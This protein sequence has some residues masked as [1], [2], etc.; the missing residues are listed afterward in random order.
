MKKCITIYLLF[1]TTFLFAQTP[2]DTTWTKTFGGSEYEW[3]RAVQQTS[4][5]GYIVA[6]ET[7]SWGAGHYDVLLIKTDASGNDQWSK[8]YGGSSEDRCSAIQKTNDNGYIIIGTTASY[9]NGSYDFWLIK[10]DNS[11]NVLW[12]KTYGGSSWDWAYSVQQTN[13]NG[14]IITGYTESYGPGYAAVWL[15]KTDSLGNTDWSKTYGGSSSDYG[16]EVQQTD[17]GGYIIVGDTYSY[18]AGSRD[19]WL[20]KTNINGDTLW[21]K[22]FGGADSD[23]GKSVRQT[24]DNGYILTGYT[25]SYGMGESDLWLIKTDSSGNTLW[26][27]T[28]GDSKSDG[29]E[30]VRITP[31]GG[32]VATGNFESEDSNTDVFVVKSEANGNNLWTKTIDKTS[33]D[34]GRWIMP[35]DD[36]GFIIAGDNYTYEAG[37]YNIWLIKLNYGSSNISDMYFKPDEFN[38]NNYPNPFNASTAI[39]YSLPSAAE[40]KLEIY[41]ILG[42]KLI[43]L[44][45]NKQQAGS[46]KLVWDGRDSKG[47]QL[48]SGIYFYRIKAGK[49]NCVKKMMY[50][51]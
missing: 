10:T 17:D 2:P 41:G 14:Y 13:D 1:L 23:G 35:T 46:Y 12:D 45:E 7:F 40:V 22:T 34:W 50:I 42:K 8:T 25:K 26:T 36:G 44:V 37:E 11:G 4:D 5:G 29:G 31:D 49:F 48:S 27:E 39:T 6:G 9:G 43:T 24:S 20:I 51:K 28:Y 18:G 38:L 16:C 33:N 15:I 3:G 30:A 21:T 32:Y 47:L 19:F